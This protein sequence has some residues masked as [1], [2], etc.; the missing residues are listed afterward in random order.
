M[1]NDEIFPL[2]FTGRK[3]NKEK[4]HA[5]QQNGILHLR[6]RNKQKRTKKIGKN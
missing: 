1:I 2:F 3:K 6:Q 4:T 5:A